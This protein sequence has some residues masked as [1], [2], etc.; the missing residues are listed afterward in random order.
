VYGRPAARFGQGDLARVEMYVDSEK[1]GNV[2]RI[3]LEGNV[4]PQ[5][6][7]HLKCESIAPL[8]PPKK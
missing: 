3:Y 7:Q 6:V 1:D 8:P 4:D 2:Q 5:R